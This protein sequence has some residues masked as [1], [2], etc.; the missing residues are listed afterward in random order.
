MK[1]DIIHK[2]RFNPKELVNKQAGLVTANWSNVVLSV[3]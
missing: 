2:C 1:V 3:N